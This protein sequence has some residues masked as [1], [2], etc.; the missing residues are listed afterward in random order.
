[1]GVGR[2]TD[3]R[4]LPLPC[5]LDTRYQLVGVARGLSLLGPLQEELGAGLGP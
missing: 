1:M 5:A 3:G 4:I 2:G